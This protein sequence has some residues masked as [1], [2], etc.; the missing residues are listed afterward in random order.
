MNTPKIA[1]PATRSGAGPSLVPRPGLRAFMAASVCALAAGCASPPPPS[2]LDLGRARIVSMAAPP[3][4][5]VSGL[6]GGKAMG[7]AVGAGSGRGYGALA[8]GFACMTTGPFFPLCLATVLPA[9]TAIGAVS[10]AAIGAVRTESIDAMEKKTK[11][12][13]DEMVATPYSD[14]LARQLQARLPDTALSG[15]LAVAPAASAS[16]E[17]PLPEIDADRP[18]TIE[19][20][21]TEVGTEGKSEFALRLVTT[22]RVRRAGTAKL[23]QT[24]KEVQ[25]D[26]E[27]TIDQWLANDSS[28]LR[29]VLNRCIE[30][31]SRQLKSD[32]DRATRDASGRVSPTARYSTSCGDRARP[33]M[34]A[35]GR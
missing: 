5:D 20:G 16:A 35:S 33:A 30:H 27:L 19:V 11:A 1:K 28:A 7:A 3:A 13:R 4:L 31:A 8:G 6:P 10:G 34:Q 17:M 29:E 9:T 14:L 24:A 15:A 18:W 23:W 21:V 12:L 32:F 22:V 26:T 2:E 25:S